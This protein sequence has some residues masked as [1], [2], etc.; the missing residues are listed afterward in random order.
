MIARMGRAG[1][2]IVLSLSTAWFAGAGCTKRNPSVCCTTELDCEAKGLPEITD[3]A[4]GYTC[5]NNGCIAPS[6]CQAS[7]DCTNPTP[8]CLTDEGVCAQCATGEDCGGAIC[9][10]ERHT[11]SPCASDAA[12]ATG[13]CNLSAGTCEVFTTIV[14]KY[15]AAVCDAP[16]TQPLAITVDKRIDT[17]AD[18]ECTAIVAQ[19]DGPDICVLHYSSIHVSARVTS[20]GRRVL[21][22]VADGDVVVDGTIDISGLNT[23]VWQGPFNGGTAPFIGGPGAYTLNGDPPQSNGIGGAGAAFKTAGG[24]GGDYELQT[25]GQSAPAFDAVASGVLV[26]G[27]VARRSGG[28]PAGGAGGGLALVSCGGRVMIAG[29]IL[30]GGTGGALCGTGGSTGGNVLLQARTIEVSGVVVADGGAGASGCSGGSGTA[31]PPATEECAVGNGG[32][33]GGCGSSPPTS[34]A[35]GSGT[36]SG[37]GGG[38]SIGIVR[39][40]MP[41]GRNPVTDGA[42]RISPAF[43]TTEVLQIR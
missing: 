22:F 31:G 32:G 2:W 25:G 19:T 36:Q 41:P 4:D 30:A 21:A 11:C 18:Q 28:A 8:V 6:S 17:G 1:V 16:S 13:Y 42:T 43:E 5:I 39:A 20:G 9:D 24:A 12:C 37:A 15:L 35:N 10:P 3:C 40:A 26:A 7:S 14:P 29:K 33:N 38:G 34:G 27:R 23:V